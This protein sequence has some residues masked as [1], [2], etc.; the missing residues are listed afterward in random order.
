MTTTLP[1]ARSVHRRQRVLM[2]VFG[3]AI[4]GLLITIGLL[5]FGGPLFSNAPK[6]GLE[7]DYLVLAAALKDKPKDP[8]VLM[9]L[10]ETEYELGKKKDALDHAARAVEYAEGKPDYSIRYAQILLLDGDLSK[11]EEMARKEIKLD[12]NK[13]NAGARFILGQ[14]LFAEGKTD[15]AIQLM[16]QGLE[17]DYTA[18]DMRVIYAEMLAKAGKKDRAVEE[19]QTALKFLP[20][21]QRAIDGLAALGVTYEATATADPHAATSTPNP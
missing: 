16:E 12:T 8:A 5:I 10:A 1:K 13:E 19:Y 18:A 3:A 17:L 20:D 6:S 4:A 14:I 9:T 11:A 2:W 15:D 21:S 7:R